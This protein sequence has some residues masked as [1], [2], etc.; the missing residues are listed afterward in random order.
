MKQ[1]AQG[2]RRRNADDPRPSKKAFPSPS[3]AVSSLPRQP[4]Q[5]V[6]DGGAWSMRDRRKNPLAVL[7]NE[8]PTCECSSLRR[9]KISV[10][11]V[12]PG[13]E[14]NDGRV[15]DQSKSGIKINC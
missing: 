2:S 8:T 10:V 15:G 3:L 1:I 11:R 5:R 12:R 14:A 6:S 9:R 4:R 7:R 13:R